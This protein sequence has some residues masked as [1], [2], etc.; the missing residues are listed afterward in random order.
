M[1]MPP[2]SVG[3]RGLTSPSVGRRGLTPHVGGEPPMLQGGERH[4]VVVVEPN[5]REQPPMMV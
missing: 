2:P 1:D 3:G 4:N 5:Q